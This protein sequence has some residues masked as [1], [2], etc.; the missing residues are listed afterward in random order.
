M[1]RRHWRYDRQ[2][3]S[4]D[5]AEGR[6]PAGYMVASPGAKG[7]GTEDPGVFV[8]IELVNEIRP[9]VD[10][11][12]EGGYAGVTAAT[13][14]LLEHW[15]DPERVPPQKFFFCQLEAIETLIWLTEAS[16]AERVGIEI[17]GDGGAFRRLCNKMATGT[18]KTIVMAM[19]IAWQ[20]LNKAANKQDA[21]FSKNALVIAPGLTVRKRLAVLKPEGHENYYEQF[22]IVPPDMMQTLRAHGRVHL[23]NWHKLGWETEEKI[24]KKKGVDKRGAKSDEAWLRDVLEDMAKARNLIVINDEAHH[25]WRIPAGETIK[26]VSREEKE[27]A[28]KW[29]G[30]LDRIHKAREIL[31]CF[32]LSATPYVPS[33]KRNV[34]EA[35][36]GWIVSDFGLND[37]IEAGLVKTPRVVVRDD[38]GVDSRTFKS[39]LYHIYG[40]KDEHGNRIRDD[41]NR[42]AEATESLPQLVMNA[43][44]LLGRDWLE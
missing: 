4:F 21:R 13:R 22:D 32:D 11:W 24:A 23:I 29:I 31:T 12:R 2:R 16:A 8:P 5:L 28:T 40:A 19:L 3:Q 33:G 1:P 26:G 6:R 25:A 34:E 7:G 9:R 38:A 42:K 18:G 35:L 39:K 27:E 15:H 14:A 10:A 41:L 37:S 36:F 44:L 17:P 30:G 43:Y 20:V